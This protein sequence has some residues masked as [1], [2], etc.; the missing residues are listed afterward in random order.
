MKTKN[1]RTTKKSLIKKLE[2]TKTLEPLIGKHEIGKYS[3]HIS[4]MGEDVNERVGRLYARRRKAGECI[5]CGVKVDEIN[6]RTEEPY[7]MCKEHR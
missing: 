6:P 5:R 3:V 4:K 1:M 2:N 7:R